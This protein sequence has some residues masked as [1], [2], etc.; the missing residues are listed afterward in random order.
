[1]TPTETLAPE[2]KRKPRKRNP[3]LITL[4]EVALRAGVSQ[5]TVSVVLNGSKPGAPVAQSTRERIEKAAEALGYQ[6]N[7]AAKATATGRFDCVAIL[8]STNPYVST[9]PQQVLQGIQSVLD[10]RNIHVSLFTL[11]DTELTDEVRVPKI[12][13]EWMADGMIIDYT[14][15]VPQRLIDLVENHNLPAV[16]MNVNRDRD[17]VRPDDFHAGAM[18]AKHLLSLEHRHIAYVDM[19]NFMAP[20]PHYSAADRLEGIRSTMLAAGGAVRLY[21]EERRTD[22][23]LQVAHVQELLSG[24]DRPTAVAAYA[25]SH[26]E[27]VFSAAANLGMRIPR[28]LSIAGFNHW[29]AQQF[30]HQITLAITPEYDVGREAAMMLLDKIKSPGAVLKPVVVPFELDPGNTC[31]NQGADAGSR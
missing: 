13:R 27:V 18:L 2:I 3:G 8:L 11:P 29:P 6:A 17:C 15:A 19:A 28:D 9:L 1:M 12:L 30:G 22:Y 14:H 26:L 21:L 10:A 23:D 16:W 24:S 7:G 4:R 20:I 5:M 25:P 31:S